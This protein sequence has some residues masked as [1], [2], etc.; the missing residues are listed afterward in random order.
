VSARTAVY[1]LWLRA[2]KR[3]WRSKSQIIGS[4]AMPLFFLGFLGLGLNRMAVPGIAGDGNYLRFLVPGIIGMSLLFSSTFAGLSVLWDREFGFLKE[5]MV[6]PVSRL[7]IVVGRTAGGLTTGLIQGLLLLA[8]SFILGFRIPG[9]GASWHS[10][11]GPRSRNGLAR[12]ASPSKDMQG[13]GLVMNF[14]PTPSSSPA[15]VCSKNHQPIRVLSY[16]DR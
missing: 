11:H 15:P 5:I 12:I 6:A 16:A 4:I 13:F 2:L 8:V 7:A 10:L 3:F 14:A 9:A 1:V